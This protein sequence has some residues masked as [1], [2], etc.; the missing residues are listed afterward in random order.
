MNNSPWLDE[1]LRLFYFANNE[2]DPNVV[3][4]KSIDNFSTLYGNNGVSTKYSWNPCKRVLIRHGEPYR[5]AKMKL[6]SLSL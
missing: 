6:F 3:P 4:E 5:H 1:I 2:G